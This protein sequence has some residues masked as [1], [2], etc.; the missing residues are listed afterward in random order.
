MHWDPKPELF[1]L[2]ILGWPILWYNLFFIA[3]FVFGFPIFSGIVHR[4]FLQR[5]EFLERDVVGPLVHPRLAIAEK[6][7]LSALVKA[8]NEW[9]FSDDAIEQDLSAREANV[10][11]S[12]IHASL[13]LRRLQLEKRFAKGLYSLKRQARV[14]TDRVILYVVVGTVLGARLG[15][16]LFYERPSDYLNNLGEIFRIPMA[17]LSSHGAA[18]GILIALLIYVYR[19]KGALRGAG[20]LHVLDFVVVPTAL[21][22][23]LIRVGNFFNQEILGTETNL[24]W[25]VVFDHPADHSAVVPRHPVQLY[26]AAVYF[27]IFLVLWR[28]SFRAK[29]LGHQGKLFGLFLLTVFGFRLVAECLKLEQSQLGSLLG[30]T[31]GQWLSIPAVIAGLF[32]CLRKE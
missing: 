27:V 16:Y 4:Y 18:V 14:L 26:E 32:F 1:T 2:P 8:L 13:A 3:G 22:G 31:M 23:A 15:H 29:Y 28:L 17:G 6:K 21:A 9:L 10:A 11:R 5:P 20:W 12:S 30:L 24:P 19:Y 7:G 25:G